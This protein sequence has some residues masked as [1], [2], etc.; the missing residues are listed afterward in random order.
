[1]SEQF[2][3]RRFLA[4]GGA[5]SALA[6]GH[7]LL[8]PALLEQDGALAAVRSYGGVPLPRGLFTLG[9]AS[10]DPSPD[11]FVLWTRLAPRPVDGGGMPDRPVPVTWQVAE[12]E[13]FRRI[14]ASGTETARPGQGHAV[15]AEVGDLRPDREYFYRFRAGGELSPTGRS[16]TAPSHG[17]VNRRLK[18]AFASCQNWQDG[19]FTAY[20]HLAQEDLAFVAFLGDY[21][22]E[23]VPRTTTVRAHEGT[24]EPYTLTDYR[25][26]H[27][28][29]KTDTNLQAA[30]A[31]FPWIT[32]WDDHELDNNWADEIPQDPD[33]QTHTAF[34]ARRTAA[35]QAYYEH[36]PLRRSTRPRGIDMR[37]H[38]RLAFGRLATV[39][40]LDTRQYRSD[41]PATLA[42]A[43][44]PA[45]TMTG[46][47]QEKWLVDG[48]SRSGTRWNLLANQVM[49][50]SNDRMA[51]PEEVY[52]FDNWDGYRAQRRRMLEFFGSGRTANPVVLT[53]D[54]HATWVCDLKP[55]FGDPASPVVGAE[56]TGTSIS[57]GGDSDP[58]A[59]HRTYDP[60]M[61]ESPHW[62]Y[63]GNQ[64][65]YVVCDVSPS[66][67]LAS[68]RTV[69]T[70]W[71]TSGTTVTTAARF[72][73][74]AGRPGITVVD[75]QD[76]RQTLSSS[77][78]RYDVDDDQ[79]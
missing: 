43:E 9:V 46:A 66:R 63:I 71:S 76:T 36:M 15:H 7:V 67:L 79:F 47:A 70:V 68:L 22:Y 75:Q 39:H 74:E 62:K 12:D 33:Q 17:A 72:Q 78:R 34:L 28:Q 19:Y 65:G 16:R 77:A 26:R 44:D 23:S 73:V 18:F 69:S 60:I 49:W 50:A 35:F 51:G 53:G 21:I 40:V 31:A 3:R 25:N 57:S 61:A 41:Q 30:H 56:I 32:T 45:R 59:F 11:G 10:G 54:R 8:G 37:L 48:M 20:H 14:R 38:R 4:T 52:D 55:E 1:M 2:P 42:E 6:A 5:A 13:R 58:A 29:Y 24:D 64:R 27:A